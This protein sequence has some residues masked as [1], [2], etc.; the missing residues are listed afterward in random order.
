MTQIVPPRSIDAEGR[1]C[2]R[3]PIAYMRAGGPHFFC[4]RCDGAFDLKDGRQIPN[5]A[6]KPMHGGFIATYPESEAAKRF[7]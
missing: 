2:G 3:K 6:W 1:C 4:P 7:A 5:W